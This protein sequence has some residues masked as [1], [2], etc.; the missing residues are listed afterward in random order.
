[1]NSLES[2]NSIFLII[3]DGEIQFNILKFR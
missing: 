1:M 2:V 3:Q